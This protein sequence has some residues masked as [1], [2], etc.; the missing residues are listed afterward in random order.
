[1]TIAHVKIEWYSSLDKASAEARRS[2]KPVLLFFCSETCFFC[3]QMDMAVYARQDVIDLVQSEFVPLYI[4]PGMPEI[5]RT[6]TVGEVPLLIVAEE[7][8]TEYERSVGFLDA[9]E[10]MA[11]C[12]LALVK[13]YYDRDKAEIAKRH[14]ERLIK[15]FPYGRRIP[16]GVFW[17][18]VTRYQVTHDR[19]H[20]R[21]AFETLAGNHPDSIWTVRARIFYCYPTS[22]IE[23]KNNRKN[24]LDYWKSRDAFLKSFAG[25][26]FGPS[27]GQFSGSREIE[28]GNKD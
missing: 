25:Y 5:F 14:A 1:M 10:L 12:L 8:G 11:F 3:N 20:F 6:Y 21:E 27:V 17:Q 28:G 23:W 24:R 15:D 18:G 4:T 13:F 2:G 19:R 9:Q 26:F 7:N 16:E 22:F